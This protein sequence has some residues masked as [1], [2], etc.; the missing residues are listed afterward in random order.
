[1]DEQKTTTEGM[2]EQTGVPVKP[3][4]PTATD[5]NGKLKEIT[6]PEEIITTLA[7]LLVQI[8]LYS[9]KLTTNKDIFKREVRAEEISR[10]LNEY[11]ATGSLDSCLALIKL[12]KADLVVL[13][14]VSGRRDLTE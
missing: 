9:K 5:P 3:I 4:I 11:Y 10:V 12:L 13:E 8:T 7:C 6:D 2:T 1:M 14:H